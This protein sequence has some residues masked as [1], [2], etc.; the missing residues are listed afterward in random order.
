M[1]KCGI[2]FW[3]FVIYVIRDRNCP[4]VVCVYWGR[5]KMSITRIPGIFQMYRLAM[6]FSNIKQNR[7]MFD[8][9]HKY[10]WIWT[11]LYIKSIKNRCALT[12]WVPSMV[13]EWWFL[14]GQCIK[15][16]FLTVHSGSEDNVSTESHQCALQRWVCRHLHSIY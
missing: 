9:A 11:L 5:D 2:I 7:F 8:K 13:T 3:N 10:L 15:S 12:S 16:Y 4:W 14:Q 6:I 1:A